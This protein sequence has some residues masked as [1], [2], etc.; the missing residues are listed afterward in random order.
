MDVLAA[1]S[2]CT[3]PFD[4]SPKREAENF[5]L[6]RISRSDKIFTDEMWRNILPMATFQIVI[7]MIM[8]Y[9]GQVIFFDESFNVITTKPRDANGYATNKLVLNTLCFNTFMLMNIFNLLNCRVNTNEM[10]IFTNLLNNKYFWIVFAFEISVQICF[11][12]WAKDPLLGIL[13]N[14]TP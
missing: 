6:K 3:E 10:N 9:A 11:V 12:W 5:K 1:I 13:L 7:L 8:M 4:P 2:I 14:C